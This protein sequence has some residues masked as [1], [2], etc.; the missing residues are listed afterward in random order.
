MTKYYLKDLISSNLNSKKDIIK[1]SFPLDIGTD[2]ME[3]IY[4]QDGFLFSKTNYNIEK[5]IFLE[6]KQ[7]ERK[8]VITISLK[9]N[10]TYI[11][12]GDKKIIPFKEGFTT[13]SL[14]ENTQGFREFK[15]KQIN[16]IR[17]ILSESFLRR[18]FQKSLVEKYFFNKQNLQLIDFRLTSI[19][20]QFLLNDILNCSLVGELANIYKQGKIFELLSLEIS[21]LQ[22]NEDD[23]FLD[24]YDRSAILKAKEILLNNLQNPPSIV[25]LAKM[26]HLSEVKL[27]RGFKQIYKTSPYQLLV[28]HK[29]NLAKNML[30]SGEYNIN[31]IALQ[32]GYKFAN[33]FTNAFYKEFKI[34]PKDILKK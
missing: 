6:A 11:N 32:V 2:Y 31:E 4:I 20:S 34:R 13:I 15:D 14:F 30:E 16:Q 10:T 5:P 29:M 21:K 26:V 19:Q 7:E 8:F 33:N 28:S 12:S 25:S 9:G 22:K 24:D 1:N 27:K 18:N 3:K 23:I 17:L